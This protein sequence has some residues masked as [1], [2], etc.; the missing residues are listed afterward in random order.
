MSA[1][2]L[3]ALLNERYG[4]AFAADRIV[5][6][7]RTSGS[8]LFEASNDE[9]AAVQ[10]ELFLSLIHISEPTRLHKVSRMPSSA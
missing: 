3:A 4:F 1:S 5:E 9:G 2:Q 10:V 6:V 8:T 7:G